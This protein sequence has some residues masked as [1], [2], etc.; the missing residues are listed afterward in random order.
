MWKPANEGGGQGHYHLR[1][2]PEPDL[3]LWALDRFL[4]SS[5]NRAPRKASFSTSA[6]WETDNQKGGQLPSGLLASSWRSQNLN[7]GLAGP[8]L[9]SVQ[10][11]DCGDPRFAS[12][13]E[14]SPVVPAL[15]D[16]QPDLEG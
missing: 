2:D 10:Q 6:T 7:P 5:T 4:G 16:P 1:G 12:C 11:E 13:Q 14:L 15:R 8:H 9:C 3:E